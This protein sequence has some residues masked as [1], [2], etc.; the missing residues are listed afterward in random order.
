MG[1]A[2]E[3][4]PQKFDRYMIVIGA[5][6]NKKFNPLT[7]SE[8]CAHFLGVLS[9]AAQSPIRGYL[10]ITE[11]IEV[12]AEDIAN[13]AGGKVTTRVAAA[14]LQKLKARGVLVHDP[15]MGAWY[16]ND[17]DEINPKPK[18]D[19]TV[20]ERQQRRRERIRA[21]ASGHASVTPVS[22]RDSRDGHADVTPPEVEVEEEGLVLANARTSSD[23]IRAVFDAWLASTGKT[24]ATQLDP[25][26]RKIITAALKAYPLQDVLDAVD[27]WRF[28]AH[29][30]GENDRH[31]IY[32]D[33]SL[34]LRDAEKI[35][36]FR[37]L[38]RAGS[39]PSNVVAIQSGRN[40]SGTDY[41]KAAGL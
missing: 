13:E 29:H 5:G 16:V 7:D 15:E 9:L 14:A 21:E 11:E 3:M 32:N 40:Q 22:R 2:A 23:A 10:L 37:D 19:T 34:L 4:S 38:K 31:T 24:G 1:D 17:W 28:S 12:E 26:R 20:N 25:K 27:G 18:T 8:R 6:R 36:K 41:D 33:L 35:E 30:R 39:K